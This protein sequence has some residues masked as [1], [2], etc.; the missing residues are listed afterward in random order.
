M[1]IQPTAKNMVCQPEIFDLKIARSKEKFTEL[2]NTNP[3]L[4]VLDE[5]HSQLEELIK[6]RSPKK[7]ISAELLKKK[8][9]SHIGSKPINE[10]GNWIY[11]PWLNKVVHVLAKDEFIE[12]R[13]NR[14]QYKITPE[15]ETVLS[16]K[17]IGIIGLSVG[18]SIALT[19]AMERICGEL[20]IADF[21][22]I[23][24]SN[25]NRIKTGIHNFGL[26]KTI[27][28]ARE[29]AEID[30]YLK[31]T[32]FHEGL[33]EENCHDFFTKNGKLDI[34][35]EVCDGLYSK[36]MARQKAK[37]LGIA[38]VMNSSDRGTTDI[39]RFDLNPDLPI[40]H[41]LIDHLD[42]KSLKEAKTNEEKVPY[43]LPMLGVESSS[44]RLKASMLEIQETITTWPQLAS[45]V[46]FGG[47]ICTDVCRRIL[48]DQFTKSGRYFVDTEQQINN[49]SIS[50]L[51]KKNKTQ[52]NISQQPIASNINY[53]EIIEKLD[54]NPS[55]TRRKACKLTNVE[56]KEL[57]KFGIMAPSGGNIQ[58]WKWCIKDCSLLLLNDPNRSASIL[59]YN[60]SASF[61]S[62]GAA[63]ENIVLKAHEMGY[64]VEI[65]KF[66]LGIHQ[67]II[68]VFNFYKHPSEKTENHLNDDLVS[69]IPKR[70]TNRNIEQYAPLNN[71][72]VNYLKQTISTI[73]GAE[74][75]LF[76]NP[77]KISELKRILATIDRLF[78]TQQ[79]GHDHFNKE[80]RWTKE[81]TALT[82]DGID[83]NT[84]DITATERAGLIVSKNWNVT[85]HLKSW[86]LGSGFGKITKK[87][88][89]GSSA[90]GI[91]TMSRKDPYH[92]YNGGR[93]VQKIL[94]SAT[95][96]G[97]AFQ[98]MSIN[99]FLFNK[100]E[101]NNFEDIED[102]KEALQNLRAEFLRATNIDALEKDVFFFRLAKTKKLAIKALRRDINDV[103]INS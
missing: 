97:I 57:I 32:C 67:D 28:V 98:P 79:K 103:I 11:F 92:F 75:K 47:G 59:N 86:S 26:K 43:L 12:V 82:R 30:P 4:E 84:L 62:F 77:D 63:T 5:I 80:I 37:E 53:S 33:T 13:T 3:G 16:T 51:S 70:T 55:N 95:K 34:C 40:L 15:E 76:T 38:V 50:Y 52:E 21:D 68:G 14:N 17:K 58:P 41:G 39:E 10:Y 85:K 44:E 22:T 19:M 93:A 35:I 25:L 74:L 60:N 56:L 46:V 73:N 69:W 96:K 91:V 6:L 94:L 7:K 83:L 24:L 29:I 89:A 27:V 64:E 88:I 2:I 36:I 87:A 71:D 18:K 66:P 54:I 61:V 45:G 31:V 81:E 101:D 8:V 42:L 9:K 49:E 78:M 100:L 23:E 65:E 72:L 90:L 20:I 1:K 48:L 102:I 99:T